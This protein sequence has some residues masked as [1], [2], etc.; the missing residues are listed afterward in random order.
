MRG[1]K[2]N[3]YPDQMDGVPMECIL[4]P[5]GMEVLQRAA[6]AGSS[7]A[8]EVYFVLD[9]RGEPRAVNDP[10]AWSRWQQNADCGVARTSVSPQ[11]IVLTAFDGH[12]APEYGEPPRPFS[13]RVFGGA[14]DGEEVRHATRTEA[15]AAHAS[16]VDWCRIGESPDYGLTP[17]L[18][19]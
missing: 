4:Q 6:G 1:W 19:T 12:D 16:L 3:L 7:R 15:V 2:S 11:I 5:R 17:D 13:S 8:M 9:D 10:A 18:L 14:L